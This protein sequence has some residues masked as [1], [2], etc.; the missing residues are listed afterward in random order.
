MKSNGRTG[1]VRPFARSIPPDLFCRRTTMT[2]QGFLAPIALAAALLASAA[3]AEI[4][5]YAKYPD[6]KGQ[7]M[8]WGPS[9]PDL[10]G[11]LIRSGPTGIFRTRFDPH[12]P[13]ALGQDVPFTPEYEA[14][15]E[16]NLKDQE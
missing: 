8:R 7:W 3:T 9:G 5:D 16:A 10:K 4:L 12:K 15:F 13:P 6:L 1:M 2:C 11:P 14:I